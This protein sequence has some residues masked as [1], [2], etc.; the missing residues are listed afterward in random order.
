MDPDIPRDLFS[1]GDLK[2]QQGSL[3]ANGLGNGME[4]IYSFLQA[5]Y[6]S[7]GY[8]MPFTPITTTNR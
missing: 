4:Q 3:A 6:E 1:N 5:D 8:S 7:K 2:L